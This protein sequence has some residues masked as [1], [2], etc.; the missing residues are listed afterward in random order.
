MM[1]TAGRLGCI[2]VLA[3]CCA[4]FYGVMRLNSTTP[5]PV[6][7]TTSSNVITAS[8][9]IVER[10]TQSII[11]VEPPHT[12]LSPTNTDTELLQYVAY[13]YRYLF[14]ASSMNGVTLADIEA[15][16]AQREATCRPD[17][18]HFDC[19]SV[20]S[21]IKERLHS[22]DHAR[23]VLLKDSDVE[24][25][26]TTAYADGIQHFEPLSAAQERVLLETRLRMKEVYQVTVSD[27]PPEVR[28]HALNQY[29]SQLLGELKPLL[30]EEQFALLSSY[31]QTEFET[32]RQRLFESPP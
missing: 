4:V 29:Q 11:A 12:A 28:L 24:Q 5:A 8:T 32:V 9:D 15:L 21:Q 26:H 2:T 30:S 1:R 3:C 20:E 18:E 10:L 19:V 14:T 22:A 7:E 13:K 6:V 17:D 31:E 16:L 23:Y 27:A 25:H